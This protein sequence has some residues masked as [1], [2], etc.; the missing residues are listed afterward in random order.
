VVG[1]PL[2]YNGQPTDEIEL[3]VAGTTL[4]AYLPADHGAD[5]RVSGSRL[6]LADEF[7]FDGERT[8]TKIEGTLNGGGPSLTLTASAGSVNCQPS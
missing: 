2:T 5:L 3:Q 8:R 1:G 7:P 4:D 6:T